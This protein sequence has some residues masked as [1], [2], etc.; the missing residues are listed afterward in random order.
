[1]IYRRTKQ[2]LSNY[3]EFRTNFAACGQTNNRKIVEKSD[4]FERHGLVM[5][6]KSVCIRKR[7]EGF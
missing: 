1:M 5:K 7:L 4:F 6:S 3:L 2:K